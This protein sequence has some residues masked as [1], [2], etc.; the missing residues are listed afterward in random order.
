MHSYIEGF[1][2]QTNKQT[3]YLFIHSVINQSIVEDDSVDI[4]KP[5]SEKQK[6][7]ASPWIASRSS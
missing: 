3:S 1:I 5:S 7:E 6:E 2:D 4:Q